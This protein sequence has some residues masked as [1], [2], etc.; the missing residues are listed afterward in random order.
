VHQD[1]SWT[2]DHRGSATSPSYHTGSGRHQPCIPVTNFR[3]VFQE[4]R[5]NVGVATLG[6]ARDTLHSGSS[7]HLIQSLS[8]FPCIVHP[9]AFHSFSLFPSFRHFP[10]FPHISLSVHF[11]ILLH[12]VFL[13][14]FHLASHVLGILLLDVLFS[15]WVMV[16]SCNEDVAFWGWGTWIRETCRIGLD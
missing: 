11:E 9:S 15:G 14:A 2:G 4:C 13:S 3:R 16:F 5:G 12:D 10:F 8:S 6:W 1:R 7:P